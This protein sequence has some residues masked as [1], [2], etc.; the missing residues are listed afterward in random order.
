MNT[1]STQKFMTMFNNILNDQNSNTSLLGLIQETNKGDEM[2]QVNAQKEQSLNV[3]LDQRNILFLKKVKEAKQKIL[4]GTYGVCEECEDDISQK[5]LQARPT[6]K[7]CIN[8]QEEKERS[9]FNSF[10]KRRDLTTKRISDEDGSLD[11]N[12]EKKFNKVSDIMFES[13]VD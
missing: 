1:A 6:A 3:R 5:R 10:N 7:M 12:F 4:D 9:D 11:T 2:D 13:V 8:C